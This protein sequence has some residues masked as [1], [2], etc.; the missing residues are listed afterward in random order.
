M[1][2]RTFVVAQALL[3]AVAGPAGAADLYW[4]INGTT[5]YGDGSQGWAESNTTTNS[6]YWSTSSSGTVA[7]TNFPDSGD[8]QKNKSVQ[9]GFGTLAEGNTTNGGNVRVGN[10]GS[11]SNRPAVGAMI[12]NASGTSTSRSPNTT[13][14]RGAPEVMLPTL[15][16]S[17]SRSLEAR[18]GGTRAP[19]T[20]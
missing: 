19:P 20:R 9:F 5:L 3:L 8:P 6:P 2:S 7:T 15:A 14:A 16:R 12:F 10:S 13:S 4:D 1:S 11:L 18:R 17:E